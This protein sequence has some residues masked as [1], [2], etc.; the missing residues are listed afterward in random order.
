MHMRDKEHCKL[1]REFFTEY[2]QFYDFK[3]HT[4][5]R[6]K[7]IISKIEKKMKKEVKK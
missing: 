4:E 7:K 1:N 5:N 2:E 6:V 3:T